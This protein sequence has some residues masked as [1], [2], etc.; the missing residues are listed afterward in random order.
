[1]GE[2]EFPS[3]LVFGLTASTMAM[4][5]HKSSLNAKMSNHLHL[6]Q[7]GVGVVE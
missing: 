6:L 5:A 7:L 2:F 3:G 1:M 4:D